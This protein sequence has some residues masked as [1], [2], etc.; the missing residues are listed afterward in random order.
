MK[1]SGKHCDKFIRTGNALIRGAEVGFVAFWALPHLTDEI[2]H[3]YTDTA[4]INVVAYAMILM[5]RRLDPDYRPPTVDSYSSYEGVDRFKFDLAPQSLFLVSASTSCDLEV[6]LLTREALRSRIVTLFYLGPPQTE[7][8]ILC[9]L[10]KRDHGAS[11]FDVITSY[12]PAKCRWCQQG[13]PF[14]RITGDQFLPE[15]PKVIPVMIRKEHAPRWLTEF[16][17]DLVSGGVIRAYYAP[18]PGNPDRNQDVFLDLESLLART[19]PGSS[20]TPHDPRGQGS[21]FLSS[22]DRI[23]LQTI[24]AT[25]SKIIYLDDPASR[26][27]AER[28]LYLFKRSVSGSAMPAL[29]SAEGVHKDLAERNPY[30]GTTLAVAGV[31]VTG[32][33]LMAVSQSLRQL[34]RDHAIQYLVGVVRTRNQDQFD[35]I[36]NNLQ[37]GEYG[38]RDY[39][40]HF[41]RNIFLP[42]VAPLRTTP[43]DEETELIKKLKE[44]GFATEGFIRVLDDRREVLR[45][46]LRRDTRGLTNNLFWGKPLTGEVLRL[47]PNFAFWDFD[48]KAEETTQAEVYF[49]ITAVLHAMREDNRGTPGQ[50]EQGH[51]HAIIS[52]RCFDRFND[53][54]V[55]ASLLRAARPIELD[56]SA[57]EQQ[58]FEMQHVLEFVFG[59]VDNDLGEATV[60]FLL[61]LAAGRLRLLPEHTL[62]AV[63]NLQ[64]KI[65]V[66][67]N[68][69]QTAILEEF[70]KYILSSQPTES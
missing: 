16:A 38:R 40:F 27:L 61:A 3:I 8:Q 19:A 34:Q 10:T 64:T 1:P 63:S 35:E 9:D 26:S 47:R 29:V 66:L 52:P 15:N 5:K 69:L 59:N 12:D 70:C 56:Y 57:D 55:Q 68:H 44:R 37:Y 7:S 32:R 54:V 39:D 4:A 11:G 30:Q 50:L 42:D 46:A 23:L 51:H 14:V 18:T 43:W 62:Q 25:L 49:T 65:S 45:N 36:R 21:S 6:K 13:L 67:G 31:L 22:L 28:V 24:P 48:Y 20:A 53:G 58:S 2:R 33:R 41:A 17:N 60:E